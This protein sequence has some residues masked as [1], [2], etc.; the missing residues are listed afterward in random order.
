MDS[1]NRFYDKLCM[2]LIDN[3]SCIIITGAILFI[4]ILLVML[5]F[6]Q[7][8][9]IQHLQQALLLKAQYDKEILQSQIEVQQQTLQNVGRELH[10]NIG[11]LLSV[12]K[13]NLNVLRESQADEDGHIQ[14]AE[15]VITKSIHE[16]RAL[17]KSLH[18]G[19][20]QDVGL[21]VSI[22]Q[23]LQRIR[24]TKHLETE[25]S[26]LGQRRSLGYEHEIMLFRVVQ[27]VLN[28]VIKHAQAK[29]I[30]VEL[31]YLIH[32]F[33]L[34]VKD[35]GKG[36]EPIITENSGIGL[37]NSKKRIELIGGTCQIISEIGKGT[38]VLISIHL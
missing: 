27:E 17:T 22:S 19:L 20:I 15:D 3:I 25:L 4:N 10:D 26:V 8:N 12:A 33:E 24:K 32:G 7:K 1:K 21:E 38:E 37:Q 29:Q 23:E 13:I 14:Q 16:I 9:Q 35:D 6:H 28:N 30:E 18:T 34:L 36:F 31:R 2:Y 11:Q 5:I